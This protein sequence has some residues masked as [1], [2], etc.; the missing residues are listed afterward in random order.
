MA[1]PVP[2]HPP[3]VKEE[4]GYFAKNVLEIKTKPARSSC[5]I[6]SPYEI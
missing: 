6:V 1:F 2:A 3:E 5:G 4:N